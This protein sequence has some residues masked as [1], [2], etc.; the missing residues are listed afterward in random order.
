MIQAKI[1]LTGNS[2]LLIGARRRSLGGK[3]P[4]PLSLSQEQMR[5]LGQFALDTV[6]ARTKKGIGSGD[7]P[8]PP[9]KGKVLRF[10][11][12][13]NGRVKLKNIGYAGWKAA[14]GL[15]PFRD[16][17]GTGKDG[18]H[19]LDNPSVRSVTEKSVIMAFTS[20]KARAKALGNEKRTPFFSFSTSDERK[21]TD[22]ASKLFGA[23][24]A[25]FRR[26]A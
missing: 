16:L 4:L 23:A 18:G 7:S 2:G 12:R 3:A 10:D 9:L 17:I 15:Q 13:E 26:A 5:Q 22:F 14:H 6:V 21:I 11:R 25:E 20:R 19:M 8:M 24:V 1:K